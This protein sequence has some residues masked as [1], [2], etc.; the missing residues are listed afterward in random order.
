M[1]PANENEKIRRYSTQ[2]NSFLL[3]PNIACYVKP[4]TT[5]KKLPSHFFFFKFNTY[6]IYRKFGN[7]I[8]YAKSKTYK[9][10]TKMGQC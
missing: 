10:K 8:L 4:T 3:G 1:R 2:Q 9:I 6:S 7:K 5:T